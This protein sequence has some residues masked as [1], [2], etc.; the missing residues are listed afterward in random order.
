MRLLNTF[1]GDG[2]ELWSPE[3]ST[4]LQVLVSIQGLVLTAQPYYNKAGYAIQAVTPVGHRNELPYSKNAYLLTLQTMLHLLCRPPSGFKD[5]VR[6]HFRCCGRYVL[7]ACQAYLE[8]GCLVGRLDAEENA[9][10]ASLE[11]PCSMGF[12]LALANTVPR[13]TEALIDI[14]AQGCDQFNGLRVSASH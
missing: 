13:I 10:E 7:R 8:G 1:G 9:T 2:T 12:C 14:G 5:L 6:D 4:L 3:S 11:H